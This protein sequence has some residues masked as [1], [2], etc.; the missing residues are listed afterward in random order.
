M[1]YREYL[2]KADD[3]DTQSICGLVDSVHGS[4]DIEDL[5]N[6]VEPLSPLN[7]NM[8]NNDSGTANMDISK[9]KRPQTNPLEGG[10]ECDC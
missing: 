10:G 4:I 1:C 7:D 2:E 8:E 9:S 3:L 5:L 6:L